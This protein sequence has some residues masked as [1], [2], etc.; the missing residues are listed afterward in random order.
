MSSLGP[1]LEIR[2]WT[3]PLTGFRYRVRISP[4]ER[5]GSRGVDQRLKAV[6]FETPYGEW[7]GS[8]PVSRYA[9]LWSLSE[10]DLSEL[11]QVAVARA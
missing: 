4:L 3:D 7:V 11:L 8:A 9:L 10:Q 5:T 2:D 1:P 6:V